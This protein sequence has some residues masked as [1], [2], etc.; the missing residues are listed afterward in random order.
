MSPKH[1]THWKAVNYSGVLCTESAAA[2]KK[3]Y[4]EVQ[5][6]VVCHGLGD[7]A[8]KCLTLGVMGGA[9]ASPP[10]PSVLPESPLSATFV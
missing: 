1:K 9:R 4:V 5:R 2:M 7:V 8:L 10:P 6:V 3:V